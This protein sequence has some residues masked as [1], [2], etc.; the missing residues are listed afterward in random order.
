META[1]TGP[2]ATSARFEPGSFRDRDSRVLVAPE[3]VFRALSP[4]GVEDWRALAAS[5]LFERLGRE[6]SLVA[7]EEIGAEALAADA[8]QVLPEGTAAVLRH[9][10]IPFVSYPYE[11]CFGMLRDAALLTLDLE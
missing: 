4:R 7:T 9:E 6:G 1:G 11:W 8:A 2:E 10:R 3:A 5:Q